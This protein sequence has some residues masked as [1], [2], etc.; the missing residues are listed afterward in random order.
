MRRILIIGATGVF[1]RRLAAH[2]ARLDDVELVLTS[3]SPARGEALVRHLQQ[4]Q[5]ATAVLTP[6]ALDHRR[7]LDE[8]LARIA[9]WLVIDCSGPFQAMGY[10]VPRAAL[11]AGA[12]F[13][14]LA[15]A[16]GYILGFEAA[17]DR[18]AKAKGLVA[19]TGASSSPAISAAAVEALTSGW[20]RIDSIDIAITPAGRTEIGEAAT[21]A[22]LTYAGKPVP[23]WREGR[24]QSVTGWDSSRLM[25]IP[26]LGR[27][28]VAPVET[29]DAELLSQR[30]PTASR[31]AFFAG[32]ESP[33]EQWGLLLLATLRRRGILKD[34]MALLPWLM[35]A[36]RLTRIPTGTSG[37]MVV[38]VT[39]LNADGRWSEAQWSLLAK[40]GDG[41]HVPTLPAAAAVKALLAGSLLPGARPAAH[42]F[43]LA[44]IE[45]ELQPYRITT[46]RQE[47]VHPR[48]GFM[49]R[50][51]GTEAYATLPPA[52]RA[53]HGPDAPPV[54]SGQAEIEAGQGLAPR[55]IARVIGLPRSGSDIPVTVSVD[56]AIEGDRLSETWTRNFGGTRFCSTMSCA[57]RG[58]ATECFGPI[59]FDLGLAA[60]NGRILFP[61]T[62]WRI[63]PLRLP[64]VLA[65]RSAAHEAVD[66]RGR[67]RFDVRMSLPLFGLLAHYRGWLQPQVAAAGDSV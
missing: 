56:R 45:A 55:L 16:R 43:D 30:Y 4:S 37:G 59:I 57:V 44:A 54:W 31:I 40:N 64:A 5:E 62:G 60:Q 2:L 9:P 23:Q 67:F 17:L 28:R 58:Q 49:E 63:G 52:L 11:A 25:A 20:R 12:H 6:L 10:D 29:V 39:G 18:T 14:D 26:G 61:V 32:L 8:V 24:L 35:Q 1:G 13:V 27:R 19:L 47:T 7:G 34:L 51:I 38:K 21:A 65:P 36:R 53:F 66:E 15:D 41:P 48:E 46:V 42:V 33:F 50:A 22:V 3:R